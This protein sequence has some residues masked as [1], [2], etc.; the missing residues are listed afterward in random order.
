MSRPNGSNKLTT[1][2]RS[3]QAYR[4]WMKAYSRKEIAKELGVSER[5]V[6]YY[7]KKWE[8]EGKDLTE[9]I[10]EN[11]KYLEILTRFD[12]IN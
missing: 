10:I 4:L 7:V 9:F 12:W 1:A 3:V 5:M 2:V 11:G 6:G 8:K